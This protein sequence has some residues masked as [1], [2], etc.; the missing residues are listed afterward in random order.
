MSRFTADENFPGVAVKRLRD[1]GEDVLW[2]RESNPGVGDVAILAMSIAQSRTILTFDKDFG[3][4]AFRQGMPS[5]CGVVLFRLPM[6]QPRPAIERIIATIQSRADWTGA[7]W[8][9]EPGRIRERRL[10]RGA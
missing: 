4:L 7:F 2:I 9:V 5:T 3:E 8:V 1:N 10:S 6:S